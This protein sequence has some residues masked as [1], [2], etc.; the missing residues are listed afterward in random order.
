MVRHGFGYF[1]EAHK[2]TDLLPGRSAEARLAEIY[3]PGTSARGQ[4][5]RELLDELGPTFVKFGQL[6][7]TR[8]DVVPPDIITELRGLQDDVRPFPF[9][10]AER[11]IEEDLGNSIERLFLDF[12]PDACGGGVDRSGAPRNAPE[13]QAR[14]R[15]DP[16]AGAPRQIEADLVLLYQAARL[17]KERVRA[18]DFIDAHA[19][20]DEFARQIRQELDY[21]LEGRNAQT[22]HRNFA[23]QPAR[24]RA[25]GVLDI[26]ACAGAD[27]RVATRDTARRRR[28]AAVLDRGAPR[29][30]ISDRRDVDGDDLPA[31]LLPRRPAPGEHHG[32]RRGGI[33]RARRLRRGRKA[34]R[35]RHVKA[36]ADV[37]RCGARE[38]R[39]PPEAARRPRRALPEG[40]RGRVSHRVAR[41]VLPLL[42]RER[43]RDRPD[44]GDPRG[45]PAHLLDEPA[46]AD[47]LSAAR[48][49]DR[50][51]RLG[52]RRALPG[53]QR[54]R[55]REAVRARPTARPFTPQRVAKRARRDALA[56]AQIVRERRTSSTT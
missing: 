26:H 37:H 45:V 6:L 55:D 54:V 49:C 43:Q 36:H 1:L 21:R 34:E 56:Y 40:A 11:V 20:V 28:H 19:L 12:D 50:D 16:A 39:Y 31:R 2:L 52:R 29:P 46:A 13:R 3:D 8:P 18:L 7:S 24:A 41:D 47:A 15:Q 42:R 9:E 35:R 4:H 32:A 48:P 25:E 30:R 51:A 27:A 44:P 14:G 10:Q 22:F 5:L 17:V 38:R 53:L 33:D 23:G